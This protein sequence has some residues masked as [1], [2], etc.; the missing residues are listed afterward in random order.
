MGLSQANRIYE[1]QLERQQLLADIRSEI[2]Q[3]LSVTLT[4]TEILAHEVSRSRGSIEDFDGIAPGILDQIGG[5]D[6]LQLAPEGIVRK[7]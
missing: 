1:S 3:Q 7:I 5:I 4:S 6:N 2:E